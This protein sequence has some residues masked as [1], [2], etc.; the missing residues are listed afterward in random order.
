MSEGRWEFYT[1]IA[2]GAETMRRHAADFAK[3]CLSSELAN[4]AT[5]LAYDL[6]RVEVQ[7]RTLAGT[8][9]KASDVPKTD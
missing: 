1:R 4:A 5:M 8:R 7:A 2:E 3:N 6:R 9:P